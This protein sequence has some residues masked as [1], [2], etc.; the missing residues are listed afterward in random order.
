VQPPPRPHPRGIG[1]GR[2]RYAGLVP[3]KQAA[4]FS[5]L[6]FATMACQ[7]GLG[8]QQVLL[9]WLALAMTDSEPMVG[10]VFAVRAAPNLI[11]G[12]GIGAIT[13]RMDR[14]T[15]MRLAV[16]GMT[17]ASLTMAWLLF[18]N[19]LQVWQ[20][21]LYTGI[22]GTLQSL[23]MAARQVY[24]YDV[25][26]PAEALRGLALI[27]AA[28]RIGGAVGALLAGALFQGWGG[29]AA[30]LVMG[31]SYGVGVGLLCR[32]RQRGTSAPASREP[33]RQNLQAYLR[34]LRSNQAMRSLMLSTAAAETLGFSHQVMLPILA[35][36]TLQVG[37][38]GLGILTAF[39]FIGGILG[40]VLLTV[41]GEVRRRGAMLLGALMLFAGGELLL[42]QA[43]QFA[44]AVLCV[45]FI[46]VMATGTDILHHI[47]LQHSVSNEQRG[48]AMGAWIIGVGTAPLGHLEVGYLAAF[49]SV[50][51]AL[52]INGL[53]LAMLTLLLAASIPRLRQL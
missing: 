16:L 1:V 25:L 41:I 34:A 35:R 43:S 22:L 14:R 39:R 29:G 40:V 38:T 52:S 24:V 28:Q 4:D 17:L 27:S 23:H 26:G 53:A 30:F 7:L 36:E 33:L 3:S 18:A 6:W 20:L 15:L 50:R 48:R 19:R 42:A 31:L 2:W 5:L 47:L 51:M 21:L 45:A 12:L 46:N 10:M 37:A 13:D 44:L 9:G 11:V 32:L 49:T 8:M